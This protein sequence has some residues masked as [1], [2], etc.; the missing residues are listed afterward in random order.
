LNHEEITL[1]PAASFI[2]RFLQGTDVPPVIACPA[3]ASLP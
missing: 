2:L 1:A 3:C